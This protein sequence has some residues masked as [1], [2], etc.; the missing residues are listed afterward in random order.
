M[1]SG[2]T[3]KPNEQLRQQRILRGWSLIRVA[4]E[5]RILCEQ[6]HQTV[7]VN[8]SMIWKWEQ[9]KHT[10]S[11][12]YQDAFCRL[13]KL[14][15]DKLGFVD[16]STLF[17]LNEMPDR[18]I[19]IASALPAMRERGTIEDIASEQLLL[20][21]PA[22][23]V[24]WESEPKDMD[25]SRRRLLQ[26]TPRLIGGTIVSSSSYDLLNASLLERLSRAL[27]KPSSIDEATL[28]Y[29]EHRTDSYWGD[30]HSAALASSDLLSY[31]LDHL[32]KV[33][34]L[35]EGPLLPVIRT[36]LCSTLGK[37]TLLVS[38]LY[39]DMSEYAQAR[40]FYKAT[41]RSAQEANNPILEA[42]AWGRM[43]FTYTY[44]KNPQAALMCIQEAR[45]LS[46]K[47]ANSTIRAWL[48]AVEAEIWANLGNT[49]ACFQALHET[50]CVKYQM[51]PREECYWIHFD[52][53]LLSGYKGVCF[54]RLYHPVEAQKALKEALE[55][56]DPN[57]MRRQP[58]LLTDL[59]GTYIQ[60]NEIEQACEIA[61]Q[62]ATITAQIKSPTVLQRLI[63][64][65]HELEPWKD[66]SYVKVLDQQYLKPLLTLKWVRGNI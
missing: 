60:Q 28:L 9:G 29:L 55:L 47:G 32:Q 52:L 5:L 17:P 40:E 51:Q 64:F 19:D 16:P 22:T 7:A 11:S 53:S 4:N 59:A 3:G 27:A 34:V 54:L 42:V 1:K 36:H 20:S 30:R 25:K 10:P 45:R 57:L 44:S 14:T 49:E 35:L 6:D 26:Y 58:N 50:D 39:F 15:A 65:R 37:I 21:S 33:L 24:A 46:S 23:L 13:Y 38:E 2:Y 8:S 43:S 18:Q 12:L 31:V 66:T 61:V 48:A 62:A 41:V 63:S 56:L